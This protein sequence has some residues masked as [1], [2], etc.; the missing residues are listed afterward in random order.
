MRC[1]DTAMLGQQEPLQAPGVWRAGPWGW[2]CR[3]LSLKGTSFLPP[4]LMSPCA[5]APVL[6]GEAFSYLVA[7]VGG[8]VRLDCVV[9]G[10]P[11]PDIRWIKDG[12]P[13][14]GSHL[15]H[16]LQ[17]GSLTIH[18]TEARRG[19]GPREGPPGTHASFLIAQEG[20]LVWH[21]PLQ[22]TKHLPAHYPEILPTL[23]VTSSQ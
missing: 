6:K 10:D 17:N 5:E 12:R 18:R 19:L 20:S 1:L 2:V 16:R 21:R 14:Q 13:L 8:S 7:P 15:R 23:T 3:S 9:L 22:S 11:A 4:C